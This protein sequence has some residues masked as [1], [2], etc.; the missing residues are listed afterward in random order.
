MNFEK[1]KNFLKKNYKKII[2]ACLIFCLVSNKAYEKFT[3]TE[4]LD[5]MKATEKKVN[6]MVINA[7]A[8]HIDLK[9]KIRLSGKWSSYPD[10]AKDQAEIANDK[11]EYKT[12]MIVGNKSSGTRKVGIW[13][14]LDV[15]GNQDV[16]GSVTAKGNVNAKK[17]CIGKTCID[18]NHLQMLTGQ[19]DVAIKSIKYDKYLRPLKMNT[20]KH[21]VVASKG[22]HDHHLDKA[23]IASGG[24]G[25]DEKMRLYKY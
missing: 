1:L 15:H 11:G 16:T 14:H 12:L 3:V 25:N 19:R 8:N 13:D 22:N 7:A 21:K 18:E 24:K 4:A 2:V 9:S 20:D 23:V 5:G 10:K 6:D 17:F